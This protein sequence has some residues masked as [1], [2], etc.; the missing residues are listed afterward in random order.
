M[1]AIYHLVIAGLAPLLVNC[2]THPLVDDITRVTTSD[3]VEHIR[4]EA[5]RAVIAD[6]RRSKNASASTVSAIAY[7]F[8]F[9]ITENNNANGNMTWQIPFLNGGNFSLVANAGSAQQRFSH[10][11]F[12]IVDSFDELRR[13]DCSRRASEKNLIYP[14]TG[15]IGIYEVV[16]TFAN[17][18]RVAK[19]MS[20]PETELP[21]VFPPDIEP[22][23]IQPKGTFRFADTLTFT[24]TFTGGIN[25]SL[26]LQT[27][28]PNSFRLT[29]LNNGGPTTADLPT[30]PDLPDVLRVTGLA[31]PEAGL[32]AQ[33]RDMHKVVIALAGLPKTTDSARRSAG[34]RAPASTHAVTSTTAVQLQATAKET[35]LFELDRQRMLAL[36][37]QA[38]T[39]LVLPQ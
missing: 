9:D 13:A 35:A 28:P 12:K 8:T 4:C 2:S 23:N 29:R 3:V 33:R 7:E 37:Q 19:L 25:P 17:L 32:T 26:T 18:Q 6:D 11:N 22:N 36:Q 34:I 1:R 10:R 20:S 30:S 31:P 14:I 39:V 5:Q 15:E 21:T 24:T 38:P 16:T 27:G